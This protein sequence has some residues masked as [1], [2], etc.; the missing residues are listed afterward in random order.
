[1]KLKDSS[2]AKGKFVS[3]ATPGIRSSSPPQCYQR[4]PLFCAGNSSG[5]LTL[6]TKVFLWIQKKTTCSLHWQIVADI[7]CFRPSQRVAGRQRLWHALGGCTPLCVYLQISPASQHSSTHLLA[8]KSSRETART[9]SLQYQ[10]DFKGKEQ[11]PFLLMLHNSSARVSFVLGLKS[12]WQYRNYQYI[13]CGLLTAY[14]HLSVFTKTLQT[15][16][17]PTWKLKKYSTESWC[18]DQ[19]MTAWVIY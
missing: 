3:E 7:R 1:M 19:I 17:S 18:Q 9:C 5:V 8:T 11:F 10:V 4:S 13:L 2:K 6:P 14:L 12:S 16:P 15:S